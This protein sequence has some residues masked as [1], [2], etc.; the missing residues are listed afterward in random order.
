MAFS[1]GNLLVEATVELHTLLKQCLI[2]TLDTPQCVFSLK[3]MSQVCSNIKSQEGFGFN[4]TQ[5]SAP[6][7]S[8][9]SL[10]Q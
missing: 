2:A 10:E 1:L 3:T 8:R 7:N 4:S 9:A 6:G 5:K